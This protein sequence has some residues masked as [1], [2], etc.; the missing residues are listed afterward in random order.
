MRAYLTSGSAEIGT[1]K[2]RAVSGSTAPG[3]VARHIPKKGSGRVV[4]ANDQ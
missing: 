1:R 3:Q 2:H 4:V